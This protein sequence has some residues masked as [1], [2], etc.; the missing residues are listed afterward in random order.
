MQEELLKKAWTW[1]YEWNGKVNKKG[2]L[3]YKISLTDDKTMKTQT[4]DCDSVKIQPM[5]YA[6]KN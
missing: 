5:Y 3:L 6:A 2:I 4:V 1:L